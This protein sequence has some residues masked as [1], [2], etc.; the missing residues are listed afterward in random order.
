VGLEWGP[1]SLVSTAEELLEG[2]S[3]T[4]VKKIEITAVGIHCTDHATL[5]LS[6]EVGTNFADK[7]QSLGLYSLATD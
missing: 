4:P 5:T 2:K 3:R 7:W 1:L 6:A